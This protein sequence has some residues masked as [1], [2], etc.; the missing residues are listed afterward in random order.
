MVVKGIGA[1]RRRVEVQE[2]MVFVPL[3][4][5]LEALLQNRNVIAEV[6]EQVFVPVN[7]CVCG[8]E[9]GERQYQLRIKLMFDQVSCILV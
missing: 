2:N 5:N 3:L 7:L 6:G 1:K 8:W 9:G 4:D